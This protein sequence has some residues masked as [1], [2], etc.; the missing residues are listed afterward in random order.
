MGKGDKKT[1]RG[2]LFMGSYG[3]RRSKKTAVKRIVKPVPENKPKETKEIRP[4]TEGIREAAAPMETITVVESQ[5]AVEIPKET[6][7][8]K[9]KAKEDKPVKEATEK[10][11]P[12]KA[13]QETKKVKQAPTAKPDKASTASN[14]APKPKTQKKPAA[15]K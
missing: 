4:A 6:K 10:K 11:K 14:E 7:V 2:K 3:V 13:E 12:E 8:V 9:P 5:Q 1:K 15:K